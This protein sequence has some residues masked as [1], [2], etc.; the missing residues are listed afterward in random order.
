MSGL[1]ALALGISFVGMGIIDLRWRLALF[2]DPIA[3]IVSVT[4]AALVLLAWDLAAVANGIFVLGHSPALLGIEVLPHMPI[5][6]FAFITFLPY[7]ALVIWQLSSTLLQH[8]RGPKTRAA[9]PK[10][11]QEGT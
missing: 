3:T 8:R 4:V 7:C 11:G 2:K 6:E 10:S 5:E 9:E 1:Y